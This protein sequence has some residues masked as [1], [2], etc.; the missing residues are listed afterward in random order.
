M[1]HPLDVSKCCV[2]FQALRK[3]LDDASFNNV[4]IVAADGD[5]KTISDDVV[6][7]SALKKA[8]GILG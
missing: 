5:F 2:V 8:V 4:T 3:A 6:K 1:F 7:D